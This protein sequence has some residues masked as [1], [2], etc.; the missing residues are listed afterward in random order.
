MDQLTKTVT[1]RID[2]LSDDLL[3]VSHSIHANPELAFE[4]HHACESIQ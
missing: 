3:A 4:E 1:D 2:E